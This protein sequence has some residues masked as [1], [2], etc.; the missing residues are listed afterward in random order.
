MRTAL[1]LLSL[2]VCLACCGKLSAGIPPEEAAKH[3]GETVTIEGVVSKHAHQRE[4]E[5]SFW[6]SGQYPKQVSTAYLPAAVAASWPEADL[7]SLT[8]LVGKSVSVTGKIA[9]VQG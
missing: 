9:P 8:A 6:T 5:T 3:V 1:C 4:R 7:Q 2:A